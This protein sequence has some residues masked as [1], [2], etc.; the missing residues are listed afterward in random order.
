MKNL[1]LIVVSFVWIQNLKA[2]DLMIMK[3]GDEKEVKVTDISAAE[4]KYKR[5][6]NLDGPTYTI[7]KKVVFMIK[8]ENGEKDVFN[9]EHPT[10]TASTPKEP[11]QGPLLEKKAPADNN[12]AIIKAH[13][14]ELFL[15]NS[16]KTKDAKRAFP[17]MGMSDSS[18]V[19]T[20][21]LEM[22]IVP[23]MVHDLYLDYCYI[24]NTIE[25]K[26]KTDHIIYIDLA[27]TF[28][29]HPDGSS[30][31]YFNTE[32][33]VVTQGGGTGAGVNVGGIAN[34]LGIGGAVGALANSLSVGGASQHSVSTNYSQQ[35]ILAIPPHSQKDLSEFKQVHI[36][37]NEYKTISDLE[38]YNFSFGLK[39]QLKEGE[40]IFLHNEAESPYTAQYYITYSTS[41]NF[42]TYSILHA[43]LYA[44][45]VIGCDHLNCFRLSNGFR[46]NDQK[47][48]KAFQ[49]YVSNF[50]ED[51]GVI[52]GDVSLL[53]E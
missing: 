15:C 6:S 20:E 24:G 7:D 12:Q 40:Y 17:V 35:R 2:Q 39:G 50:W 1:M 19:S 48:V 32:Q 49:K 23:T 8:Y 26:N 43:K 21:D 3:T 27:N 30:K 13:N 38:Y 31:N 18:L 46:Y 29:I 44:R 34:A 45:C 5:W 41:Q 10:P 11:E 4:I 16:P 33:I 36:R 52:V 25:L 47:L 37:R 42:S 14:P 53:R 9:E 51:P 22:R 28:R